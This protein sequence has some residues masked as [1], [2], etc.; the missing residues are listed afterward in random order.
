M[1]G[2]EKYDSAEK[3]LNE[4]IEIHPQDSAGFVHL[5]I[6]A[7]Q[8]MH[9]SIIFAAQRQLFMKWDVKNIVYLILRLEIL[10]KELSAL[11][12]TE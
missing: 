11:T 10:L 2:L 9:R 7:L 12:L 4:L 5:G 1:M 6:I 8:V 3:Y